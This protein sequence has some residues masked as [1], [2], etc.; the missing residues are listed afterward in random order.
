MKKNMKYL[1]DTKMRDQIT[2][3]ARA[4]LNSH[5]RGALQKVANKYRLHY[6]TVSRWARHGHSRGYSKRSIDGPRLRQPRQPKHMLPAQ[7]KWP[8]A[9]KVDVTFSAT[10]EVASMVLEF[11]H[12]I[13]GGK[14]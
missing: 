12:D 2:S 14:R 5:I 7:Y 3:E 13:T 6:T 4:A 9:P 11:L 1:H 10:A 8:D